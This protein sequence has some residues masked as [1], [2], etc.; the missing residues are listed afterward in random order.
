MYDASGRLRAVVDP[1]SDTAVYKYDAVGNLLSIS[2]QSTSVVSIIEFN[3][4]S[5]PVGTTVTI[6]GTGFSATPSQNTVTFNGVSASV[7]SS[8]TTQIVTTVPAGATTG[9]IGVTAPG[10][11]ATST[12]AFTVTDS[13][14]APTIT[15]FTPN[16]GTPGTPV[17]V[18]G[19]NFQAAA[20]NNNVKFNNTR[21]NVSSSTSTSIAT[22]VPTVAGSGRIAVSTPFGS[23]I[24]A[25]DF[26]IPPSPYTAA[27]VEFTGRMSIGGSTLTA[28]IS[29]ANKIGLVV[30]DGTAGQKVSL[31]INNSTLQVC[32]LR[33]Y[34]PNN[35]VV[36]TQYLMWTATNVNMTLPVT[37]TYTILIDPTDT[38]TGSVTLTLSEE[39]NA[40]TIVINGPSATVAIN[41]VGQRA[42]MTFSGTAGQK[43]NL[44]L[45]NSTLPGCCHW[46][47]IYKPDSTV[48][49]SHSN[50]GT[51]TNLDATLPVTGIYT[52]LIDPNSTSTG[53][54]TLTLS[55]E[56]NAGTIVIDGP[57]A[58]VT[59]SR[60]GQRAYLTFSGTA[61]QKVNLGVDNSTL[62][63]CCNWIG[64]N[65]PDGTTLVSNIN[66]GA[67]TNLD[68]T[69]PVTGTYRI[70]IDPNGTSTGGITL[71][72]SEEMNAGTI[73]ID[74][75]SASVTLSRVG[76]RAYLTFSGTAGQKINLGVDNSTL[77]GCCQQLIIYK[78]DNTVLASST[79][80]AT[81]TNLN[82]TL[83]VTGTYTI[84]IDPYNTSTGTITLT[85]SEE[86]NA[87]TIVI[88]GASVTATTTRVG[89]RAR[90]T[91]DGTAGQIASLGVNSI[92]MSTSS[93]IF[94]FNPD[95]STLASATILTTSTNFHVAL[96][97]TGT[98]TMIVDPD[99]ASTGSVT[100][101]LSSEVNV[102]VLTI[103]DPAVP[104]TISRV[105]QR[106]GATFSGTSGQQVT[107]RV[108][109]NTMGSVTVQ[110]LKPDGTQQTTV[111]SSA[112]SF[113]TATQTLGT[114][115]TY[116]ILV[117]PASTNTGSLN[118]S[119][120]SP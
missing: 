76:Q 18:T 114:T 39:I 69:L 48:L 37:G 75:P 28:T 92:T 57:S 100:L 59:L 40:G 41:R 25:A 66:F 31:G 115:G 45:D 116:T 56:M 96:P 20:T 8:T 50:F 44:G 101:T 91:F 108:T 23:A 47:I 70:L 19:T 74:G 55:E 21:A 110:M 87:G 86:I 38:S 46:L 64:I 106:A 11:S 42:Y 112:S 32:C 2:R 1:G 26:F 84:L 98:Y 27:D 65:K 111:T 79:N 81:G 82:A 62:P 102:G 53:T 52:I 85:L 95:G 24:S 73:V 30:F 107:A 60:V 34:N 120:T 105:G 43:V 5:G 68:T 54:V 13:T 17:T 4:D 94:V 88:D 49:V 15:G 113:N 51:G 7:T 14:G 78:P 99:A 9:V 72:L 16:I 118:L 83:P 93:D 61:G 12:Q 29:T 10:G 67:G 33:I 71:T 58:S 117:D 90:L 63:G 36:G 119:V 22:S 3:P 35:T 77:P 109:G 104:V 6:F 80:M 89:Q 97:A 103:N